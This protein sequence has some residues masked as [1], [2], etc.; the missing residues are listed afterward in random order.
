MLFPSEDTAA[1]RGCQI[2]YIHIYQGKNGK[3]TPEANY[4]VDGD[5]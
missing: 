4:R 5:V 1:I 2:P 3:L